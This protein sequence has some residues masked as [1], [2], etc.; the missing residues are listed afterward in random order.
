[1]MN[2]KLIYYLSLTTILFL[3]SCNTSQIKEEQLRIDK[4]KSFIKNRLIIQFSGEEGR[5][6]V[7]NRF[8]KYDARLIKDVNVST[9]T[10]VLTYD[11]LKISP[12]K[13]KVKLE[14]QDGVKMLEFD[15][16]LKLR[17]RGGGTQ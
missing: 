11:T 5:V 8:D 16:K 14:K 6:D 7:L 2:N 9:H 4:N 1:M 17:K 13:M 3:F 15:K 12:A 10:H